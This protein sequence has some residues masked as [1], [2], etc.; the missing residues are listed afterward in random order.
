[1]VFC[2]LLKHATWY[3]EDVD[4]YHFR[5][6]TRHKIDL[7]IERDDGKVIG[8]EVKTSMS[9]NPADFSVLAIFAEFAGDRCHCGV[10]FYSGDKI[11][12]FR[13]NGTVFHALPISSLSSRGH[14]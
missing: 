10:L 14:N 11:L 13:I 3:E 1:M 5:D 6:T 9:V 8:V 12:P 7:V 4:F 2:E